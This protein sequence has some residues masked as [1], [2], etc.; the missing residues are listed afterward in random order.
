MDRSRKCSAQTRFVALV[1]GCLALGFSEKLSNLQEV[2]EEGVGIDWSDGRFS[3]AIKVVM[4][5]SSGRALLE[6]AVEKWNL[7]SVEKLGSHFLWGKVSKTDATLTRQYDAAKGTEVQ[8][9]Q[10]TVTLRED[11]RL[12]DLALDLAHELTHAVLGPAWDPY[13]PTLHSEKY[14]RLALEGKG[15]EIDAV[16]MECQVAMELRD[17]FPASERRC[18]IY[19]QAGSSIIARMRVQEE[20]YKVGHYRKNLDKKLGKH[21]LPLS[22]DEP[23]L[24]S[25]TGQAPY[26]YALLE[27]YQELNRIACSN[28]LRR[29]Q[30]D[31]QRSLASG[32]NDFIQNRCQISP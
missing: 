8:D 22:S 32:S 19:L 31:A 25:S 11:Q 29:V 27:E 20:F 3:E 7:G 13:D 1:L 23:T 6:K 12:E 9:R 2:P 30:A 18:R 15:G 26:P 28:T 4:R 24:V 21:H 5:S 17:E 10:V 16:M 14:I